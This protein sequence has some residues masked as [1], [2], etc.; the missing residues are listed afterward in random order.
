MLHRGEMRD[1][2]HAVAHSHD[3][4]AC[5]RSSAYLLEQQK[6]LLYTAMERVNSWKTAL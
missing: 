5:M 3:G 6:L 2:A 4:M 1:Y